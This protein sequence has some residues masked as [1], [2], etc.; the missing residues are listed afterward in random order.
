[1]RER[2]IACGLTSGLTCFAAA[3][4]AF[5]SRNTVPCGNPQSRPVA[6]VVSS[7]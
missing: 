5:V 2:A 1:M 3:I 7:S 6:R 4:Y